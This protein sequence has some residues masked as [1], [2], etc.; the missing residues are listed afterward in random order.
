V[1]AR[2]IATGELEHHIRGVRQRQR[3]RRDA[4]LGALRSHLP[5][6]RVQGVPAGLHL[7]ITFPDL[8]VDDTEVAERIHRAGVLV[9]P[10]SW[11]R[12][13]PGAP[14]LVLGYA[15]HTPDELREAARRIARAVRG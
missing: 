1:L 10:L 7:L 8:A 13:L 5:A 9:H 15:A 6:A 2:R 14:G 11:H 12:Q 4:L 3:S